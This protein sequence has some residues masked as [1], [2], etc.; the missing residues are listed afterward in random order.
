MVSPL[1]KNP[2]VGIVTNPQKDQ[3]YTTYVKDFLQSHG[4]A[5]EFVDLHGETK[6][7][8]WVV[9]G[10]DGTMLRASHKAAELDVPLFGINLGTLGFLTGAEKADGIAQLAK[11]LAG[12][13][14]T[15]KRMM[16]GISQKG[17]YSL[18]LNDVCVGTAGGL[19]VF[20]V[21]VNGH[22]LDTIRADGILV[23]T[24]TGSTAYNLSAGGPILMPGSQMMVVTPICPHSLGT[25]PLVIGA[26][27]AVRIVAHSTA[28][29]IADGMHL[30]KLA[31]G[32]GVDV[33]CAKHHTKI[34]KTCK[35]HFYD[36]LRAKK[37]I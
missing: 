31:D 30:A 9:L 14:E 11:V 22:L 25:R 17:S 35:T 28:P 36:V 37:I 6:A 23:A 7:N 1:G 13:Y 12:E 10:G 3:Q 33:T 32:E 21:Y 5:V 8:L 20:D 34:I 27:D 26:T 18:A 29:L 24:P 4:A 19:K 15:E 2:I 16:L